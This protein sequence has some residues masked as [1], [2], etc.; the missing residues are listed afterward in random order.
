L[1][2]PEDV[3][4]VTNLI[5]YRFFAGNN[6]EELSVRVRM[7]SRTGKYHW[8]QCT[9][10]MIDGELGISQWFFIGALP[11]NWTTDL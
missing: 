8:C 7:V 10:I 11:D 9:P 4:L 5:I 6:D 3:V 1:W 2:H